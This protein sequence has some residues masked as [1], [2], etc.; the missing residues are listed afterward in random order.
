MRDFQRP[1]RSV[2]YGTR[3]MAATSMP[4]ASR[5]AVEVLGRGGSVVD[6]SLSAMALLSVIEPQ[7][8]GIGGDCFCMVAMAGSPEVVA[9]NGSGRT[10]LGLDLDVPGVGDWSMLPDH[11]PHAVTVPGA[12]SAWACLHARFGRLDWAEILR[13]AIA[14][15][16]EGYVVHD[17][18]AWDWA[19]AADKL[20]AAGAAD[21]LPHGAAPRPGDRMRNPALAGTLRA[22]AARGAAGFY[23]GEVAAALVRFL[24]SRGGVHSLD[25]LERGAKAAEFV[26]PISITWDGMQVWQC[27]PN[28]AGVAAL[29]MLGMLDH[30]E[31]APDGV[32]GTVRYHRHLEA[33]RLAMRDRDAFVADPATG[34]VPVGR[35]TDADYLRAL[36]GL[37]NDRRALADLPLAGCSVLPAHRDTAYLCVADAQGNLCSLIN[38]VFDDFGGGL[39]DPAT[40]VVLH[41]RGAGFSLCPG[42][43]NA[44][45]PG[46]RPMHTI[47]PAVVTRAGRPLMAFGVTGGHFQPAGQAQVLTGVF[48]HGLD[49]QQALDAPRALWT[50]GEVLLEAGIPENLAAG[51]AARGHRIARSRRPHGGGQAILIDQARGLLIGASDP[52]RDGMALGI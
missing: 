51:L 20:R 39:Y 31:P 16:E 19:E 5:L 21:L 23:A 1:G 10:P 29:M 4:D 38:S 52:R 12:V 15:A 14:A 45:A 8:T 17:R 13:P 9:L 30:L 34:A 33:F 27:P 11:T 48:R 32:L 41:N 18:V 42:H 28:G 37:V 44:L 22:I 24:R 47:L 35:L 50:K 36:A 6:A 40:G 43:P 2:A 7:S 25:D 49:L 46:K 26:T 3:G